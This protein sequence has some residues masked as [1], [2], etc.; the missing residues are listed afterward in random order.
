MNLVQ[1]RMF[2]FYPWMEKG[3]NI[4]LEAKFRNKK[5]RDRVKDGFSKFWE[6]RA[7]G[8]MYKQCDIGEEILGEVK[9]YCKHFGYFA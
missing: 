7:D 1:T 8:I 3:F 5:I 2:D 4:I 9:G 6:T